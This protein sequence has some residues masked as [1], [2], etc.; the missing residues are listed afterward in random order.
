LNGIVV[1]RYGV[2][3]TMEINTNLLQSTLVLTLVGR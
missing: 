1:T 2:V 3:G